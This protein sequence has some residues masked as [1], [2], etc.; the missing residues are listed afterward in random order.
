MAEDLHNP[1]NNPDAEPVRQAPGVTPSAPEP[2]D[3]ELSQFLDDIFESEPSSDHDVVAETPDPQ[4]GG[5][6]SSPSEAAAHTASE[7]PAAPLPGGSDPQDSGDQAKAAPAPSQDDLQR[8]VLERLNAQLQRMEQPPQEAAPQAPEMTPDAL[9]QYYAPRVQQYIEAGWIDEDLAALYPKHAALTVHMWDTGTQ[10]RQ[11]VQQTQ[12]FTQAEEAR[13][14]RESAEQQ[15]E[16]TISQVSSRGDIFGALEE[17]E[18]RDGFREFLISE[19]NPRLSQVT[20]DYLARQFYAYKQDLIFDKVKAQLQ[21]AETSSAPSD[22]D[23]AAQEG[24]S[25]RIAPA[26]S[27]KP[28]FVDLL[29]GTAAAEWY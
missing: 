3:E 13:R 29:E 12:A 6:P 17:K 19:V 16:S 24:G 1:L 21:H 7:V 4:A 28:E 9:V 2:V 23:L 26:A 5:A 20:P 14:A 8:T 15:L 10:L 22:A 27:S 25:A 11:G 18:V